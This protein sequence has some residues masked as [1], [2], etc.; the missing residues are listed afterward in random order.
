M[1]PNVASTLDAMANWSREDQVELMERVWERLVDTGWVPP[2]TEELK[3]ELDRR[4]ALSDAD[5]SRDIPLDVALAYV[6]RQR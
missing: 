4:I 6:R 3:A 2:L 5:P 1:S